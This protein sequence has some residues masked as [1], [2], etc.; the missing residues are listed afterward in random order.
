M[1]VLEEEDDEGKN[2]DEC[3]TRNEDSTVLMNSVCINSGVVF[4]CLHLHF[5]LEIITPTT[6]IHKCRP[7]TPNPYATSELPI[8]L[9][10]R[11]LSCTRELRI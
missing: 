10:C 9:P 3:G 5:K 2:N 1:T 7:K 11:I 6:T 4:Y 8:P